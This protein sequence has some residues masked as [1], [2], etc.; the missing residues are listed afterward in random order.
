MENQPDWEKINEKKRHEINLGMAV[1]SAV[2]LYAGGNTTFEKEAFKDTVRNLFGIIGD[3]HNEL[4]EKKQPQAIAP[5]VISKC[6]G[7]GNGISEKVYEFSKKKFNKPLC[8]PC[9]KK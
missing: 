4:I 2:R 5:Q 9:Q 3:L 6:T 8:I 1:N 7:C